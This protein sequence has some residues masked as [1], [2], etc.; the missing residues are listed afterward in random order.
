MKDLIKKYFEWRLKMVDERSNKLK[1]ENRRFLEYQSNSENKGA[2]YSAMVWAVS[3][4][5]NINELLRLS[6]KKN[7]LEVK[8]NFKN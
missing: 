8:L 5:D 7:K 2:Y 6:D 1:D 4:E 3:I